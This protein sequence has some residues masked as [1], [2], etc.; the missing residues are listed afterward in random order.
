MI[1]L[2][3]TSAHKASSPTTS[4]VDDF[5]KKNTNEIWICGALGEFDDFC[6]FCLKSWFPPKFSTVRPW[7]VT[8]K[9]NRN[10]II[11]RQTSSNWTKAHGFVFHILRSMGSQLGRQED[12]SSEGVQELWQSSNVSCRRFFALP[13]REK[14]EANSPRSVGRDEGTEF[15]T[16]YHHLHFFIDTS[17]VGVS[18]LLGPL[19]PYMGGI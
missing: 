5:S 13:R 14:N 18:M 17:K 19:Q 8:F 9:L 11:E 7:K 10:P 4:E 15:I 16:S 3:E 2:C 1:G 12:Y 6:C